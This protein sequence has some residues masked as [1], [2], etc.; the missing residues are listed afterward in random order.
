MAGTFIVGE[1]KIR[2]GVYQRRYKE[3]TVTA[4]ARN[5]IGLGLIR[6]NWG[7]LNTVVDFTPDTSVS[8]TFGSGNT[9]DLITE[10]FTGGLTSGHFVRVG[11]GGTAP[12][13][14]LQDDA[15]ADVLTIT[16]AYV[17][18]RAF[19]VSIRDSLTGAGREC[20]FYE[21]TTEFCKFSFDI[22]G[23]QVDNLV[24]AIKEDSKDFIPTKLS[25]GSGVMGSCTQTAMTP[26]TQPTTTTTEYSAGLE[27]LYCTFGNC[28]CVDTEDVAVHALVQAFIDRI[29][30][31]GYYAIAC[32]AETKSVA[33]DTRM[34]H[35]AAYNDE[36]IVYVLNSAE[37]SAGVIY[38]GWRNAARI[39]GMIASVATNQSLTH[40]V[41]SGYAGLHE[42]LTPSEIETALQRGCL[43]LTTNSSGQVWIEQ[44]INTLV[45]CDGNL[46]EGWKKIRRVKTRFELQQRVADSLDV[47]IGNIN[48]DAD[49]RATIIATIKGIISRMVG[50]KKLIQGDAY[51]DETNPAQGDSA[52][53]IIEVDD[54][55]SIEKIYLAY[56]FRYAAE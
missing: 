43:V 46:D 11:T 41:I 8:K 1:T 51:E 44:G 47:L 9:E 5:G 24:A 38:D 13:I 12:V 55:D 27:A 37:S 19:T 36:K 26:G 50:E 33:L 25:D 15:G 28:L 40:S 20:I 10:M 17:G 6:A 3:G 45:T 21:G 2:P 48:N 39:G 56:R 22:D 52:W 18:D 4:G 31:N 14:T 23:N 29:Y 49:G 42:T 7:P 30:A 16:G 32:L 35:A 54:I 53:F 34:T